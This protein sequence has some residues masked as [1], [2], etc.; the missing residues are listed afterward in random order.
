MQRLKKDIA[1]YPDSY[2]HE[3]AECLSVSKTGIYWAM[4]RLDVTYK[5]TESSQSR[6]RKA[7]VISRADSNL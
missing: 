7:I 5:K 2:Y 1:L 4:K 3:R 6:R